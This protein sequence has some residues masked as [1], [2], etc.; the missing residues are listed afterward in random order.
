VEPWRQFNLA[1]ERSGAIAMELKSIQRRVETWRQLREERAD[2][3]AIEAK[4]I[5]RVAEPWRQFNLAEDQSMAIASRLKTM[6]RRLETSAQFLPTQKDLEM[7]EVELETT[8]ERV[9]TWK[10]LGSAEAQFE[11]VGRERKIEERI[12]SL[13]SLVRW[14]LE[15]SR[16][17][18]NERK[19]RWIRCERSRRIRSA[20]LSRWLDASDASERERSWV[21]SKREHHGHLTLQLLL[22]RYLRLST[23]VRVCV[24]VQVWQLD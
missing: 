7:I 22:V 24:D 23:K 13:L 17:P 12:E 2:A 16:E 18:T 5:E 6:E 8:R 20:P 15:M 21:K 9:E 4:V 19:T 10:R 14:K 1:E 11:M 3:V